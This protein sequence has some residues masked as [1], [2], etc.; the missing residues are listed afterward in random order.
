MSPEQMMGDGTIGPASD[1]FALGHIAYAILTGEAYWKEEYQELPVFTAM[2][3]MMAG[4]SEPP[5]VRARRRRGVA[6]APGFDAWFMRA[7]AQAPAHRF[8]GASSQIAELSAALGT[9]AP[10]QLLATPPPMSDCLAFFQRAPAAQA[11]PATPVPGAGATEAVS[12]TVGNLVP[13]LP[14]S[15]ASRYAAAASGVLLLAAGGVAVVRATASR[16]APAL[17]AATATAMDAVA[18]AASPGPSVVPA[19]STD[20]SHG[21][22]SV[23]VAAVPTLPSVTP[24]ASLPP[25]PRPG[26]TKAPSA[27]TTAATAKPPPAT[28]Q[29]CDPPYTI[30]SAGRHHPKPECL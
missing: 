20:P 11:T 10:R 15:R 25:V 26:D 14:G 18:S 7:T 3:R 17:P 12:G 28:G 5:S 2:G 8:D 22:A 1:L 21:A 19:P 27:K 4:A 16:P 23:S 9:P 30:D 13:K 24:S 6:L 29:S